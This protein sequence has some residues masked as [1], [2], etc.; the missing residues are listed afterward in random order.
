MATDGNP[1]YPCHGW[2][3]CK[4]CHDRNTAATQGIGAQR[5]LGGLKSL[6]PA[7]PDR[8]PGELMWR[9]VIAK[10]EIAGAKPPKAEV[11]QNQRRG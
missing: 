10:D 5:R 7:P 9:Q 6:Q 11:L 2:A 4:Q 1:D 3:L 8:L